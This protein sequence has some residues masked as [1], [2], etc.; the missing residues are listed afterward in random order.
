MPTSAEFRTVLTRSEKLADHR[1]ISAAILDAAAKIDIDHGYFERPVFLTVMNG[2]LFF[3][4]E[5]ALNTHTDFEFD[6]VH[7]S[8]YHGTAGAALNWVKKPEVDLNGRHVLLV[9]DILD[10][11]PT[12]L[13]IRDYCREQGA[14]SV[15]IAVL[16]DKQHDRRAPGITADYVCLTLPDRYVF[17][18]GMDWNGHGRNLPAIYALGDEEASS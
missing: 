3:A 18:F 12:L 13:A 2:G 9:D 1:R 11:G 4:G 8:R 7:A 16:A 10:E 6:Y 14:A 15:R 17:G 5:L